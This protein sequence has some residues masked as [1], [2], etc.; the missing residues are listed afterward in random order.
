MGT[1]LKLVGSASGENINTSGSHQVDLVFSATIC[2]YI[3][4]AMN[5]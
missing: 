2:G 5:C 4:L 1:M 3:V